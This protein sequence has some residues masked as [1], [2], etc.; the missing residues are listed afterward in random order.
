[1]PRGAGLRRR[2][3]EEWQAV[4]AKLEKSG[5]SRAAFCRREGIPPATFDKWRRRVA[6]AR[7]TGKFVELTPSSEGRA[8]W[9]LE[10]SLPNGL[11]LR[12]RG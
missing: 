9:D 8:S 3:L 1:M 7:P 4:M 12:F 10:V 11:I 6:A 2:S 5:V